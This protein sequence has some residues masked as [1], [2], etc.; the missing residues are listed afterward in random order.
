MRRFAVSTPAAGVLTCL[1]VLVA[2]GE[3]P[4]KPGAT[5]TTRCMKDAYSGV[6]TA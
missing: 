2:W 6:F 1:A 5:G 4:P 3:D